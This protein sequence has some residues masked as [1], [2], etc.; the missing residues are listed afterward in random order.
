MIYLHLYLCVLNIFLNFHR[1]GDKTKLFKNW[2]EFPKV[3]TQQEEISKITKKLDGLRSKV[4]KS[5][6]MFSVNYTAV[7]GLE[8]LIELKNNVKVPTDWNKVS[9]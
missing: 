9:S 6:G 5:L 4:A 2:T 8:F 1:E 3:I 7:S